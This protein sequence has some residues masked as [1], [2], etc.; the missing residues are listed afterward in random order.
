M[1][2]PLYEELDDFAWMFRGIEHLGVEGAEIKRNIARRR[3]EMSAKEKKEGQVRQERRN[4]PEGPGEPAA[5]K[6]K[7]VKGHLIP[8][9]PPMPKDVQV[10][11]FD[12]HVSQ[13]R[14]PAP[15]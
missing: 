13:K 8:D 12:Y 3:K 11:A 1:I 15:V 2:C 7:K 5:R 4:W 6:G 10:R 9:P 14:C